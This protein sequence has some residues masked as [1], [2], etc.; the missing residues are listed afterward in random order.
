MA[1]WPE[2]EFGQAKAMAIEVFQGGSIPRELSSGAME[3]LWAKWKALN[4]TNSLSLQRLTEESSHPLRGHSTYMLS[5]GDDFVYMY[6]GD[7]VR[8]AVGIDLTGRLLSTSDNAVARDLLAAYRHAAKMLAPSFVRFSSSR[9]GQQVWQGLVLP[10]K[11]APGTVLLVCYSELINR[12]SEVCEHLFQ[13]S[14]EAM[15]IASPITDEMG[16]VTDGWVVMMNDAARDFLDFRDSIGNL[17]LKN[18]PK[19]RGL[20]LCFRLHPPVVAGTVGTAH[21]EDC[22]AQ[23]IRFAQVF[24]LR[25]AGRVAGARSAPE[26]LETAP[27]LI[28][29][30]AG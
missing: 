1:I 5:A 14:P 29:A 15:L 12:Q 19:L 2:E 10:I 30:P 11:L 7:A 28:P 6:M 3:F 21:A 9:N 20:E 18:L 16:E 25:L 26:V 27:P 17:R 13:V 23:I 24:A 8:A 4:A 22:S